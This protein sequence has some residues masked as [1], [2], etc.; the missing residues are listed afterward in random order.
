MKTLFILDGVAG[1]G[2]SDLMQ[3]VD[4][5]FYNA[6]TITKYTTREKRQL[7]ESTKT[8]LIFVT[9]EKF[10]QFQEKEDDLF[11]EYTFG[12][13]KYGFFKSQLDAAINKYE[14]IFVIVRN[15]SVIV[16]IM[17]L[18]KNI[19]LTVPVYIYAA[20]E[21]IVQRMIEDGYDDEMISF[22]LKRSDEVFRDYLENDIYE[23][24]LINSS[25]NYEYHSKIRELIE[26]YKK[27]GTEIDRLYVS[28]RE[29]FYLYNL[30]PYKATIER[31]L[32][33]TPYE[34]NVFLMMKYR[35]SNHSF[36]QH[37]KTELENSG[38]N[39]IRA[40][41]PEWN[42]TNDVYNPIAVLYC[43]K[44]GIA[45][46]DEPEDGA[47]YSPNVMYELGVMHDQGKNCL[48]LKYASLPVA[49]FDLMKNLHNSYSR[50]SDFRDI[51]KRWLISLANN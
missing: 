48:I 14:F 50:D 9:N 12:S 39:C 37:I 11:F 15:Q 27:R 35:S 26:K 4:R 41:E 28:P 25:D 2:K 42:I 44:Y 21:L 32:S 8:D 40:D 31:R 24:I 13:H 43:C 46:F 29:F 1:S 33:V 49:P 10:I 38:Y 19:I 6:T 36:Y 34:K 16:R 3:Y 17:E 23:M 18:Y 7:E 20:K 22:R 47:N 30:S 51:F 5:K 45:L